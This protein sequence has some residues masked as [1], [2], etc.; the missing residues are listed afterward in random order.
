MEML[1]YGSNLPMWKYVLNSKQEVAKKME[2]LFEKGKSLKGNID[3]PK[4]IYL[5][6]DE[7]EMS[8]KDEEEIKPQSVASKIF[9]IFAQW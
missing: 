9:I 2:L 7:K 5:L 1:N 8:K 3:N 6:L 4:G